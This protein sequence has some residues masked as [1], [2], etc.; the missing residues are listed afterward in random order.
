MKYSLT[1]VS[2]STFKVFANFKFKEKNIIVYGFSY[3]DEHSL[4]YGTEDVLMTRKRSGSL[5][6]LSFTL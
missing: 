1:P 3:A 6:K 2:T 5:G 4:T